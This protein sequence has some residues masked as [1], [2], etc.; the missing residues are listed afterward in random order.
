MGCRELVLLL[1][2]LVP[3]SPLLAQSSDELYQQGHALGKAGK[4]DQAL[5][6]LRRAAEAGN[7]DA[8]FAVG[9][10][11]S[12]GLG[13]AQSKVEARA[14]FE[15]AAVQDHPAALYNLGLFYDLGAGIS[16]DRLRAL[17]YYRRGGLA[18]DGRAAYNAGQMLLLG[19]GVAAGPVDGIRFMR[20]AAEQG[21]PQAQM[22]LGYVHEHAMGVDRDASAAIDYYA[23][24]EQGGLDGAADLRIKLS[25][26]ITDEALAVERDGRPVQALGLYD[27]SCKY[28][29]YHGCYNAGRL[30]YAGKEVTRDLPR[31]LPDLRMACGWAVTNA[32][33][34]LVGIAV[35]GTPVTE[36]DLYLVGHFLKGECD[37]GNQQGCYYLAW[38]KTRSQFGA[39]DFP[40]AQKLL[41]QACLTHGYQPACQPYYDMY[42]ASLPQTTVV[43]PAKEMN[44]LQKSILG[45]MDVVTQSL[46]AVSSAGRV[47]SGSY[48]GVSSY[49]PPSYTAPAGGYSIQDNADF[50]QFISSVSSYGQG[51]SCRPGNPYC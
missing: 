7:A 42:N 3:L 21:I 18:G 31:A 2:T 45:A 33:L 14:W 44:W 23:R 47:S 34:G 5:P 38:T 10:M 50:K 32:C 12:N 51:V 26:K 36:R 6:P 9:S 15:R 48:S 27:L 24:A 22:A 16:Q 29:E 20:L 17:H 43:R 37:V 35:A 49:S 40:A 8:Q 1:V 13:V 19:D 28:G 11:Y 25:R 41:A 46:T 4:Y 39:T 30:R